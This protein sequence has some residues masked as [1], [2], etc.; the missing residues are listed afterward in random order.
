MRTS[1]HVCKQRPIYSWGNPFNSQTSPGN[2]CLSINVDRK[3]TKSFFIHL[4]AIFVVWVAGVFLYSELAPERVVRN[5]TDFFSLFIDAWRHREQDGGDR[6]CCSVRFTSGPR[7]RRRSGMRRQMEAWRSRWRRGST[8]RRSRRQGTCHRNNVNKS[9]NF[10][11]TWI[12][13]RI[14]NFLLT[15]ENLHC[16]KRLAIFPSLAVTHQTLPDPRE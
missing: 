16:E 2:K 8:G 9:Y 12:K 7:Q 15:K 14:D 1:I 10:F 5:G 13:A 11:L 6:L 3:N 4:L